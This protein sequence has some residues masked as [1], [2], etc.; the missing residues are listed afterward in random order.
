MGVAYRLHIGS[1]NPDLFDD[2]NWF[3][4]AFRPKFFFDKSGVRKFDLIC[5]RKK[6]S[7]EVLIGLTKLSKVVPTASN[8]ST[9]VEDHYALVQGMP[10]GILF[11]YAHYPPDKLHEWA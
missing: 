9:S 4:C 3:Y 10:G 5:L 11:Y 7:K 6:F 1:S 8:I 2:L